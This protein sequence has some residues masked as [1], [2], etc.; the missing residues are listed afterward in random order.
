MG[1]AE[2]PFE[3][4]P[5]GNSLKL[6]LVG[7]SFILNMVTMLSEGLTL[8]EKSGIGTDPVKQ[9]MDTL[10]DGVYSLYA[11]RMIKGTYW[12]M[13]EP[14]FS[15]NNARKDAGHAMNLAKAAG[16][17]LK[18]IRVA[19]DYLKSVAEHAG[20]D[21]GDIAGIYGA[22]RKSAGLKFENDA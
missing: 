8:A 9:L 12:K 18:T 20:G 21:K 17:D 6:K 3:D 19:D 22:A 10:F 16:A 11:E 15:A 4:Q 14:L 7:N 5:Y 13:E 1:K 2:I